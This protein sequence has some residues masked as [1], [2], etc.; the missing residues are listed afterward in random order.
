M[1]LSL[2]LVHITLTLL[3]LFLLI[4][5]II[6]TSTEL[7]IFEE[8]K[9]ELDGNNTKSLALTKPVLSCSQ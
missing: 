6:N 1:K 7:E 3:M 2:K 8:S 5:S 9:L 4:G